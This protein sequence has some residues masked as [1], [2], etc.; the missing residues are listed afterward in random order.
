[1]KLILGE[2]AF[3]GERET[4]SFKFI[5]AARFLKKEFLRLFHQ[6]VAPSFSTPPVGGVTLGSIFA[7]DLLGF[8][9][10]EKLVDST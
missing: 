8:G 7:W 9:R 4:P 3:V 6:S 2:P 5:R 1:V 10:V